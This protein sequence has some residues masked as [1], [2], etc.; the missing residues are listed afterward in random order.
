MP[1]IQVDVNTEQIEEAHLKL[2][3]L[4]ETIY[5]IEFVLLRINNLLNK[6]PPIRWYSNLRTKFMTKGEKGWKKTVAKEIE[7]IEKDTW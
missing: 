1:T 7:R 2:K 4:L 5:D 6:F 3:E